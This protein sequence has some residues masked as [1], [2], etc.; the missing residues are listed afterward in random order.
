MLPLRVTIVLASAVAVA[1]CQY[2]PGTDAHKKEQA[3]KVASRDLIDPSSAQFRDVYIKDDYVCG[4]I[5][6]KNRM[7]AYVGYKRFFVVLDR[8]TAMIDPE[9]SLS[10]KLAAD[11]LCS[12]MRSNPYSGLSSSM[13]ACERA[14]EQSLNQISQSLFDIGWSS[15]CDRENKPPLN[16]GAPLNESLSNS[17]DIDVAANMEM[18]SA[19]LDGNPMDDTSD[20]EE[21]ADSQTSITEQAAEGA[22]SQQSDVDQKWLDEALRRNPENR[23]AATQDNTSAVPTD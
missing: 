14:N 2:V 17:S 7:G 16:L 10:D 11:E 6:A 12:S 20:D 3:K 4:E 13:S 8:D 21:T 19:S 9:F 5:N 22:A 1:A 23:P 18:D 15:H